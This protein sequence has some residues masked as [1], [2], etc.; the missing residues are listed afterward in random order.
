MPEPIGHLQIIGP[1]RAGLALGAALLN[2]RIAAAAHGRTRAWELLAVLEDSFGHRLSGSR[3][4]E[5]AIDWILAGRFDPFPL[6]TH[7]FPL[8]RMDLPPS[9]HDDFS[10]KPPGNTQEKR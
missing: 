1:G 2:T 10:S 4:L 9:Y 7:S 6:I 3:A 8:D 5:R